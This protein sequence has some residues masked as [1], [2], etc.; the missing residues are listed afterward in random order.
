[1]LLDSCGDEN[2]ESPATNYPAPERKG[3]FVYNFAEREYFSGGILGF[4]KCH[5]Y[6]LARFCP[7]DG[8]K[9]PFFEDCS[10]DP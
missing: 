6:K 5:R 10:I 9:T 2:R 7:K 1:M 3:S 4:A 8:R